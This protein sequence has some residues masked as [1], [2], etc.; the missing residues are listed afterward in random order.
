MRLL[1]AIL[2]IASLV[3]ASPLRACVLE[4]AI[5]GSSCHDED[6]A[7]GTAS[8]GSVAAPVPA[9]CADHEQACACRT[10]KNTSRDAKQVASSHTLFLS[11]LPPPV[12][13]DSNTPPTV[14]DSL[15]P[16]PSIALSSVNLPLLI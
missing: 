8:H 11:L 2:I 1:S 14:A 7:A 4:K 5:T 12:L 3:Q 16:I 9:D 10:E 6:F 15:R 13:M